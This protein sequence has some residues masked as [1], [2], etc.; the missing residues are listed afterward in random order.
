[1]ISLSLENNFHFLRYDLYCCDVLDLHDCRM[2]SAT[3]LETPL[4]LRCSL[5]HKKSQVEDFS[6][7]VVFVDFLEVLNF[8]VVV[9]MVVDKSVVEELETILELSKLVLQSMLC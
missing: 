4:L 7:D 3:L 6:L 9:S 5:T 8:F 1:M 2:M